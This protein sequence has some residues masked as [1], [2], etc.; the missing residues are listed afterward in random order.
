MQL[1]KRKEANKKNQPRILLQILYLLLITS[2]K[3]VVD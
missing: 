3:V 1:G 2:N